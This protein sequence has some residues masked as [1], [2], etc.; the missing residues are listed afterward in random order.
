MNE[1]SFITSQALTPQGSARNSR[2]GSAAGAASVWLWEDPENPAIV[3]WPGFN[4]RH[5]GIPQMNTPIWVTFG[6][7]SG[8]GEVNVRM[9]NTPVH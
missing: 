4:G 8:T 2:A 3:S 5:G 1:A 9:N 6:T 7:Q